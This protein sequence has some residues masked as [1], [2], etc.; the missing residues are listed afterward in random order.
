MWGVSHLKSPDSPSLSCRQICLPS[1][2]ESSN[3]PGLFHINPSPFSSPLTLVALRN[4]SHY[5]LEGHTFSLKMFLCPQLTPFSFLLCARIWSQE[6]TMTSI[7][8]WNGKEKCLASP[9]SGAVYV[10]LVTLASHLP[11]TLVCTS[12]WHYGIISRHAMT[13][14]T[15]LPLCCCCVGCLCLC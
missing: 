1:Q 5:T 7:R 10:P 4:Q 13:G 2:L 14:R 11:I 9:V 3:L 8:N 6:E 12:L 15:P